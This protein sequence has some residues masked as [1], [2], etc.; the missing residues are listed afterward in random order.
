MAERYWTSKLLGQL[1]VSELTNR[2]CASLVIV[3][4]ANPGFCY[5]SAFQRDG[6]GSS[7]DP[8]TVSTPVLLAAQCPKVRAS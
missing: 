1:L 4:L 3:D 5:G 6:N 2:I 8:S 7:W